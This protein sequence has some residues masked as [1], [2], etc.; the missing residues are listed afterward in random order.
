[1]VLMTSRTVAIRYFAILRERR[2]V[3]RE[4]VVSTAETLQELYEELAARYELGLPAALVKF[5][6]DGEFVPGATPLRDGLE[7]ALI[8]PVAG[9]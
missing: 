4:E 7:V 8:P 3:D 6:V 9:G 2:S 1:M 5:A